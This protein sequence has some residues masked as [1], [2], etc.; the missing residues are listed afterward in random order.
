MRMPSDGQ[1]SGFQPDE[2]YSIH[3]IFTST[4]TLSSDRGLQPR[5]SR[6][7][8]GRRL[9]V[10]RPRATGDARTL[11]VGRTPTR[12]SEGRGPR[13]TRGGETTAKNA[14]DA[15]RTLR[16][17]ARSGSIPTLATAGQPEMAARSHKPGERGATPRPATAARSSDP[18]RPINARERARLPPL[19]RPRPKAPRAGARHPLTRGDRLGSIPRRGTRGS[20]SGEGT[21]TTSRRAGFDSPASHETLV[22]GPVARRRLIRGVPRFDSWHQDE[23]TLLPGRL[24]PR[25]VHADVAQLG[26]GDAL[27]P[28]PVKVRILSSVLQEEKAHEPQKEETKVR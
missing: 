18:A 25:H 9:R 17:S 10:N 1:T 28:R 14:L 5:A 23:T 26:R 22:D 16:T 3:L 11:S 15:L 13:S 7:D 19:R 21:G 2:G 20:L 4:S 6:C 8:S 27:R 24:Q 12:P